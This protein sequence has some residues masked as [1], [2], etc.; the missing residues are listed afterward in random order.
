MDELIYLELDEEITSVIDKLRKS[1]AKSVGLIIPRGASLI[2]SVVNLRLLKKEGESLGKNIALVTTDK[3]GRNLASQVGLPIYEDIERGEGALPETEI[4]QKPLPKPKEEVMEVD[5]RKEKPAP[6]PKVKVHHYKETPSTNSGREEGVRVNLGKRGPRKLSWI[7]GGA[8]VLLLIL[9][10]F[11]YYGFASATLTLNVP[12]EP[13]SKELIVTI[14]QG[15]RESK[16]ADLRLAGEPLEKRTEGK[17]NFKATGK[18][19]VGEK[20]KGK[21]T[22]SNRTGETK[23]LATGTKF[24]SSSGLFFLSIESVGVPAGTPKI[25][26]AGNITVTPGKAD[27]SVEAEEPGDKYNLGPTSFTIPSLA[28]DKVDGASSQAFSGGTTKEVTIVT[29]TDVSGARDKLLSDLSNQ[30]KEA[31]KKEGQGK[32]LLEAAIE[33]TLEESN[34]SPK[35]GEEANEFELTGKVLSKV[36]VFNEKD[37]RQAVVEQ[38]KIEVL[39]NQSLLLSDSDEITTTLKE[40]RYSQ[41]ELMILAKL[42]SRVG[43]KLDLDKLK[44][45][46]KGKSFSQ[47]ERIIKAIPEI[48]SYK[49]SLSPS[50]GLKRF[51]Y[52]EKNIHLKYEYQQ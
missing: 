4:A 45:Q 15:L 23:N 14:D 20:A 38:A 25:D 43:P 26:A 39:S 9:L 22:V 27:V 18:K 42:E 35:V 36:L 19:D 1:G 24:K 52:R 32:F 51:P 37:L 17:Q 34:A 40:A 44:R 11:S 41:G 3:V 12:S 6:L 13:F 31:L 8:L 50:W 46:L 28:T 30:N 5:L 49:I 21:I 47:G 2:Q 16:P 7:L 33:T 29:E 10:G 48:L